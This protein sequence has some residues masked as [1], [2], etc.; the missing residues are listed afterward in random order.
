MQMEHARAASIS[1]NL[2]ELPPA[3]VQTTVGSSN[4]STA[5]TT[6]RL[7]VLT[8]TLSDNARLKFWN[9]CKMPC[10]LITTLVFDLKSYG[11]HHVPERGGA[12]LISNHQSVLDPVLLGVH[13]RRQISFIAK[14]ELFEN[15][16]FSWLIRNLNAFA[17]RRGQ[18]DVAAIKEALHRVKDGQVV[19]LFPEG[20]RSKDGR[21]HP[22]QPGIAMLVRRVDAPVIPA[23]VDGAYRAWPKGAK[24]PRPVPVRVMFGAP[25]KLEGLKGDQIVPLIAQ[26]MQ[27][28]LDE[29]RSKRD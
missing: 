26:K 21:L 11:S 22:I 12:L 28:M 18:A 24:L 16:K 25:L 14:S 4:T 23:V 27:G 9:A 8:P 1:P 13:L 19:T 20:T 10:R 3:A 2:I 15:P 29:L 7:Q 6:T 17:V 5:T